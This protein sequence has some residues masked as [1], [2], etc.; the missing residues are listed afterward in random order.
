HT[1]V[2]H[3]TFLEHI[4]GESPNWGEVEETINWP[5]QEDMENN[6][7]FET[8]LTRFRTRFDET[9]EL[10][11]MVDFAQIPIG[12]PELSTIQLFAALL[13]HMSYHL[14]QMVTIRQSI[15]DW[16]PKQSER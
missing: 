7:E 3:D 8:L 14:G 6:S 16:P 10:L 15:G 11:N 9:K 1:I 13:Q 12:K 2:W 5:K 4:K